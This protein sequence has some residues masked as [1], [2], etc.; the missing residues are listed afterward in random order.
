[1]NASAL[2]DEDLV[3]DAIQCPETRILREA[4]LEVESWMTMLLTF[5]ALLPCDKTP[6]GLAR[7]ENVEREIVVIV[8]WIEGT[9]TGSKL[10]RANVLASL[11]Q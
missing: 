8:V 11:R 3:E 1:M 2:L 7:H 6:Q 10:P 9:P 4:S 5:Q